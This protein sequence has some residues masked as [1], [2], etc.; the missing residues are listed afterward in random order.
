MT[1]SLRAL[2]ARFAVA[3]LTGWTGLPAGLGLDD[4]APLH[5]DPAAG[6]RDRVGQDPG[7]LVDWVAC[8]SDTYEGGL[9]VW[10]EDGAVLLID[11]ADPVDATG[12]PLPAPELGPAELVLPTVLGRLR[13]DR[14]ERVHARLGLAVRYNP[15]NGLLLGV[16]GFVPTTAEDYRRRLRPV[17]EPRRLLSP[18]GT[19]RGAG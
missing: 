19:G 16:R 14:G 11:G 2:L 10:V 17:L 4:L 3:D 12:A 13:L 9:R 1:E 8:Q 15:D 18:S 7:R 6:G 5:V